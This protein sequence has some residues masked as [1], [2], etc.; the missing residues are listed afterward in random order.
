MYFLLTFPV[1]S[2]HCFTSGFL[3]FCNIAKTKEAHL[4]DQ[5]DRKYLWESSC[6]FYRI[7]G[8]LSYFLIRDVFWS[9][10]CLTI[11]DIH[12]TSENCE[13]GLTVR[14]GI[15]W[16]WGDQDYQ[17]GMPGTGV[18]TECKSS[19]WADVQWNNG[20]THWY[21]IGPDSFDLIIV[22]NIKLPKA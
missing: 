2:N 16:D 5:E 3:T 4:Y 7:E 12:V 1:A 14:R 21:R 6:I 8:I 13:T 17:N 19:E 11:S 15:D 10:P 9:F 22:G 18:I 20:R